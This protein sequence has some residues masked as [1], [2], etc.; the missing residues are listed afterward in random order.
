MERL[1]THDVFRGA[2]LLLNGAKLCGSRWANSSKLLFQFEGE[3]LEELDMTYRCGNA[4]V[5]PQ[6]LRDPLNLLRDVIHQ[7]KR[8]RTQH[9][10]SSKR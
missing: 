8:E 6:Q 5:N 7:S 1:E 2:Y 10:T 4:P 3:N 9:G